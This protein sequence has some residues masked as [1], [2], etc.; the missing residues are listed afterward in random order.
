MNWKK[1]TT[2]GRQMKALTESG[3]AIGVAAQVNGRSAPLSVSAKDTAAMYEEERCWE[4]GG[5]GI[6]RDGDQCDSCAGTGLL[7]TAN[8]IRLQVDAEMSAKDTA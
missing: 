5:S 2:P 4:C 1:F 7:Y 6:Y 8:A 3:T